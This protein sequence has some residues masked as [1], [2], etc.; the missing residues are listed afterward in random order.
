M[1][2]ALAAAT[3]GPASSISSLQSVCPDLH[4]TSVQRNHQGSKLWQLPE[5][6]FYTIE[7]RV[8]WFQ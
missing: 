2:V 4:V 3:T 5:G 7:S 8:N 6:Q 1:T